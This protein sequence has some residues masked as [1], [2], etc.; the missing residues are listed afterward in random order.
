MT[1]KSVTVI[2]LENG[3]RLQLEDISRKIS[4]D[5]FVVKVLL[6]IDF[7]FT[8]EDAESMDMT[9]ASLVDILGSTTIR[10]EKVL[11]RNFINAKDKESVL[12]DMIDSYLTTNQRYLSHPDFKKGVIRRKVIEKRGRYYSESR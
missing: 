5:A 3:L 1:E 7:I 9:L 10:F 11:E 8:Q 6:S 12:K 2:E 4:E